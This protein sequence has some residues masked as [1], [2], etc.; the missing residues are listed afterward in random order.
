MNNVLI[1]LSWETSRARR[2]KVSNA[3]EQCTALTNMCNSDID[4]PFA[5]SS[6]GYELSVN[7]PVANSVMH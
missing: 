2:D 6:G 4:F 7:F 3:E 5:V 1:N